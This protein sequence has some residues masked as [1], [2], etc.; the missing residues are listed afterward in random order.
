MSVCVVE[1]PRFRQIALGD[2]ALLEP[3]LRRAGYPLSEY[4]FA[5][6]WAWRGYTDLRWTTLGDWL[7]LRVRGDDGLDRYLCPVGT[8]DPEAVVGWCLRDL[9]ETGG[10]PAICMVPDGVRAR[11]GEA[12]TA[13]LDP[14]AADY[15]YRRTDL[16][17]LPGRRFSAKRNHVHRFERHHPVDFRPL[18]S[19]DRLACRGLL[20]EWSAGAGDHPLLAY[21]EEALRDCLT[22]FGEL[23][24]TGGTLRAGGRLVGFAIGEP[25]TADTWVVHYEKADRGVEGAYT[26]LMRETARVLAEGCALVNR[27]SDLGIPGLQAAKRSNQPVHLEAAWR[28]T[29]A[30]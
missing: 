18:E 24:L 22:A 2:R 1:R 19:G 30:G 12:F 8:G 13:T 5:T 3:A 16:A 4:A 25:L 6:L 11:L 29:P 21:E 15:V 17:L 26:V 10:V 7:L 23:G 20:A 28:V 9:A 14:A 27:E